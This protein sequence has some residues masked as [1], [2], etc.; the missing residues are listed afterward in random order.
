MKRITIALAL[1]L[2][3][4]LGGNASGQTPP[5][6]TG[7]ADLAK[8]AR[9]MVAD[10]AHVANGNLV[11][12]TGSPRDL[13]LLESVAVEVRKLGAHPLLAIETER[14]AQRFFTDVPATFDSQ[15]S[16]F[17]LKL[18]DIIDAEINVDFIEH[19]DFLANVGAERR[20]ASAKASQVVSERLLKNAVRQVHLGNGLYPTSALAAQFGITQ[21]ELSRIFWSGVNV[22]YA[23]LQSTGEAVLHRLATGHELKI[24]A[25]NGTN[26][27][28]RISKRP[29]HVSDGVI[30]AKDCTEGSPGCQ[31]WLP[32]GEV[33]LAPVPGTAEGV[34]VADTFFYEGKL[35]E[36]LKLTFA[37]GKLTNMTATG[38]LAAVRKA[39]DTAPAGKDLF[40]FIDIGI[41]PNIKA[42]PNSRMVSWMQAGNISVGIGGN[43]WAGGENRVA[44]DLSAHLPGGTLTVDGQSII[45]NGKLLFGGS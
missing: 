16:I 21:N 3:I 44:Y 22:D 23:Q 34:F 27:T 11:L 15:E 6:G 2:S 24:T 30:S 35:I 4:A 37:K 8:I 1:T 20:T 38:D 7:R 31:V 26:L 39:Y 36:G 17:A 33:Y 40:A 43:T 42:P 10:C 14:L 13:E 28:V 32:A 25:P 18:A 45:E 41:N 19:P 5:S 9:S 12:I 29:A